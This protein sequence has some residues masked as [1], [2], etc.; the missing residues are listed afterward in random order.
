[1]SKRFARQNEPVKPRASEH[2]LGKPPARDGLGRALLLG[3]LALLAWLPSAVAAGFAFDDR[4]AIEHNPVVEGTLPWTAAFQRDYWEHRGAAGHFRP[5]ASLSL[6]LDRW[7]WGEHAAG[8]HAT[9]V[10]LHVLVVFAAALLARRLFAREARWPW[11]GLALFAVHPVLADSVAWISGRSSMLAALPGLCAALFLA[12]DGGRASSPRAEAAGQL[13]LGFLGTALAALAKEDGLLWALALPTIAARR[14]RAAL[15]RTAMGCALGAAAVFALRAQALGS[16]WINA[17]NAPLAD[18]ALAERLL[19]AGR[20]I[21]EAL[22]LCACPAA[23]APSYAGDPEFSAAGMRAAP[24]L[25]LL[26]LIFWVIALSAALLF[27]IP[28]LH[29]GFERACARRAGLLATLA[30]LLAIG[31]AWSR[32]RVYSS[33]GAFRAAILALRPNDVPSWNDMGLYYEEQAEPARAREAWR[34]ATRLD[35]RYSRAWSNL[36]RLELSEGRPE[37][38]IALLERAVREGPK[39]PIAYLNLGSARMRVGDKQGAASAYREA[40]GLAP[41]LSQAREGLAHALE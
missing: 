20:A 2:E 24:A 12:R 31:A 38:A 4:E 19:V 32:G 30:L 18:E 27:A 36:G 16:P 14:G 3:A 41:G 28:L 29:A 9:N 37:A 23:Y 10:L 35:P 25:G 21:L 6:R 17:P 1:V 22:R 8:F 5:L 13:V 39:N 40:L 34:H 7:I 33:R 26:G 15:A 11:I